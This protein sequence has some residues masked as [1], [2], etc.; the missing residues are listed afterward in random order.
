[1]K[2]ILISCNVRLMKIRITEVRELLK[3]DE[4]ELDKLGDKDSKMVIFA[5]LSDTDHTFSFLHAI[6]MWQ[7]I[8]IL[9]RRANGAFATMD[10]SQ[11]RGS[12]TPRE[13]AGIMSISSIAGKP[14]Q[15]TVPA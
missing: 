6:M 8:D 7:A 2:S 15:T 11:D 9:C 5:V 1:M 3:Y 14:R 13:G 12:I 4:M 10:M